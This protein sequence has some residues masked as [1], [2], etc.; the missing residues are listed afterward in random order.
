MADFNTQSARWAIFDAICTALESDALLQ[1]LPVVRNPR[2]ATQLGAGEQLIVAKWGSDS[3]MEKPGQRERRK[4][5]LIVGSVSRKATGAD[6]DADAIHQAVGEVV[7]KAL[8]TLAQLP[9][10]V[11]RIAEGDTTPD[12]DGIEVAGAMVLSTWEIDYQR[13][14]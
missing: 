11:A 9:D 2:T 5:R 10:R 13:R 14:A 1:D 12:I 6:K 3:L 4:F 8:T 7:R